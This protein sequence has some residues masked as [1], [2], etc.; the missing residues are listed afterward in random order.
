MPQC[1]PSAKTQEIIRNIS[2]SNPN[3]GIYKTKQTDK[4]PD[5]INILIEQ[6]DNK[7]AVK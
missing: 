5:E 2:Q 7:L 1:A 3:I 4:F 6:A